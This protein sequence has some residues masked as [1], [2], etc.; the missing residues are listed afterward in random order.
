M[1]GVHAIYESK[2][3]GR[4]PSRWVRVE[5]RNLRTGSERQAR[6]ARG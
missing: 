1:K 4:E 5:N 6:V 2:V 3:H